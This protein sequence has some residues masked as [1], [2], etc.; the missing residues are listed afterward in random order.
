MPH[1]PRPLGTR[2]IL[3]YKLIKAPLILIGALWLS[4]A[5]HSAVHFAERIVREVSEGGATLGRL[6][7]WLE[8]HL[9]G[10]FALRAAAVAWIDGISTLAEGLLLLQ[11]SVWGEWIVVAMLG[12]L[13][14]AEAFSLARHPSLLR[15][16]VLSINALIVLY[17][18]F[19]RLREKRHAS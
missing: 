14:P 13:V 8:P 5:P 15:L 16:A 6:A 9:S 19:D 10:K 1:A 12:A 3:S 18:V 2:I 11:G 4:L 17:L 7:R